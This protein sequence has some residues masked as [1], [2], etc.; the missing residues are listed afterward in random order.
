MAGVPETATT[1][2]LGSGARHRAISALFLVLVPYI[3]I[4]HHSHGEFS[5]EP[6]EIEGELASVIWRNPHPAL[7]LR[8]T[9]A[10][11][12]DRLWRVQVLGNVN[13]LKRDGVTGDR[14][15]VGERV[16]ITGQLSTYREG[17]VLATVA[18]FE[19]GNVTMLG[20]DESSG[21]AIYRGSGARTDTGPDARD[22]A[23]SLFRVWT[24]LDRVRND[25]LPLRDAARAAKAA[26]D[27][28]L[29]DPQ[30]DCSPLG[31][32]G[33]MM[34]PHPIDFLERGPGII[35]R[36]EVWDVVRTIRMSEGAANRP[37]TPMG[38]SVGRWDGSTLVVATTG[39]SYPYLDEHGTPQSDAVEVVEHFTLTEAGRYLD[40]SAT[41]T[42][43]ETFT[44][45]VVVF[46]TR[47]EWLPGESLQPYDCAEL[48]DLLDP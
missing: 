4:A 18:A 40:W 29:D 21:A 13:G 7:T 3:A 27:P 9:G 11:G 16:R 1:K 32:P 41:V 47:W 44:E 24:V 15:Q 30:R 42:D 5:G 48:D 26:W 8:S 10:D 39:I 37:A 17:L 46:T 12:Q 36:L 35:L 14:F 6:R 38:H 43:P 23:P 33:A 20:P 31:M 34:S 45:P 2:E 28:V 25:D 22:D 19:D